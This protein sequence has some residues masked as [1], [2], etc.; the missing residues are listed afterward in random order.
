MKRIVLSSLVASVALSSPVSAQGL[1]IDV[2]ERT[3]QFLSLTA[4]DPSQPSPST[5]FENSIENSIFEER[6][7]PS[8]PLPPAPQYPNKSPKR[9]KPEDSVFRIKTSPG[10]PLPPPP[11]YPNRPQRSDPKTSIIRERAVPGR[12]LPR[13]PRYPNQPPQPSNPET[14]II[15]E[16]A[17]PNR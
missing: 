13:I 15:R 14:S 10:R 7:T 2:A 8:R 16:R 3:A 6:G 17:F 9:S 5:D 12:S 11:R 4:P 1:S